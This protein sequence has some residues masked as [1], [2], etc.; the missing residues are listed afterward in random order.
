MRGGICRC[1]L[2]FLV[3]VLPLVL[4]RG[5]TGGAQP[6][7]ITSDQV[8]ADF[9]R[10]AAAA[11]LPRTEQSQQIAPSRPLPPTTPW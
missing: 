11:V 8:A 2:V 9:V 6:E 4:A 10:A 7:R 5:Q 1:V 3:V